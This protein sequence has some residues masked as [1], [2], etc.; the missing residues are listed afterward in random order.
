MRRVQ[1]CSD[2]SD[3]RRCCFLPPTLRQLER[4]LSRP[5]PSVVSGSGLGDVQERS[6]SF[7][8]PPKLKIAGQAAFALISTESRARVCL[9]LN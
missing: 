8:L 3:P 9:I 1:R 2:K 4:I 6:V 7:V 5:D